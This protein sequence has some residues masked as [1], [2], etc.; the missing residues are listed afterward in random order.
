[1]LDI[2]LIVLFEPIDYHYL[3]YLL[4]ISIGSSSKVQ[5]QFSCTF[6]DIFLR[7]S[8]FSAAI[9]LQQR[10]RKFNHNPIQLY[11]MLHVISGVL[12]G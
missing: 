8:K 11:N 10:L 4:L 7:R 3:I 6:G 2:L 9:Y 1:M 12:Y 5:R